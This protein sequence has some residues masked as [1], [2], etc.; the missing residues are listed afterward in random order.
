[1]GT[2]TQRTRGAGSVRRWLTAALLLAALGPAARA[3]TPGP[4]LQPVG[5]IQAA[6]AAAAREFI[7]RD[8]ANAGLDAEAAPPD[9]R[10]RLR[11][12]GQPLAA[13]VA[14]GQPASTRLTVE[15]RC[16]APEAW[17]LYVPVQVSGSRPVAVAARAL[18]RD[19][20]LAAGD[21]RLA[22]RDIGASGY[23]TFTS[24]A[25]LV[26][27][28]LRR[29]LAAG[30]VLVPGLLDRPPLVRRGQEVMLEARAAGLTVRMAG[31]ARRD[32][33]LGETIPVENISSGEVREAIVRSAKS[34]EV[35]IR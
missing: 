24:L 35:L 13:A 11:A 6:A 30:A 1:M 17:R 8:P 28:R 5:A 20:I 26:G 18:A 3:A 4:A 22:P 32:G 21:V 29:D 7:A 12:C 14:G 10:L 25:D 34:V 2:R 33:R 27:Q 16:G 23:G 15:V 31:V 9:P 19:T